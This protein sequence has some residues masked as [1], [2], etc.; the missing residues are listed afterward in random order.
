MTIK[1][2]I[3]SNDK[4]LSFEV[5]P[6]KT[7]DKYETVVTAVKKIAM[8][9]P[10]FMSVT[11]GAGGGTSKFTALIANLIKENG[12]T[13]LAHL[14]CVSSTREMV[15]NQL[16][17][18]KATGIENILALRGDIP[19]DESLWHNDYKY[20]SQLVGEIMNYG[21][22][23]IGGACYPEG[24]PESKTLT[25]D[26][27]HLKVKVEAGC[28]FLTTQMFF[29]N[30]KYYDFCERALSA[31]IN[32]PIIAGIMP[33]TNAK[34]IKRMLSLSETSLTDELNGYVEKYIDSP[35][36]MKKAGIEFAIKQCEDLY[37]NG[38]SAIHIY[39]MNKPDIAK[40]IK[41]AL[42]K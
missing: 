26:V 25:E 36:D 7:D 35:D 41:T 5:F 32:I 18:L 21:G 3:K 20:A 42:G 9:S 37:S 34:N 15:N 1:E 27:E 17:V 38:V 11:Y 39:S 14:S 4:T 13:P 8:L 31:G 40:T 33:V 28:S 24:H 29:D 6:P 2:I 10:D 30:S 16:D 19:E 23:C 22:F 12:V